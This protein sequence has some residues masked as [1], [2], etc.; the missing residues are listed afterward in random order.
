MRLLA[1]DPEREARRLSL[2]KRRDALLAGQECL[3][4]LD[5]KYQAADKPGNGE[6]EL[7]TK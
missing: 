6:N 2:E 3:H 5:P 7:G 4:T 1:D